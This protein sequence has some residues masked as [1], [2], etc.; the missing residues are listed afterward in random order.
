ML[1]RIVALVGL[2]ST[3]GNEVN[4]ST[5]D[6]KKPVGQ[7]VIEPRR[8]GFQ[9][10]MAE[11]WAY[12]RIAW[13]FA[14]RMIKRLYQGTVLGKFWLLRP[15][16][17]IMIGALI[18]GGLLGVPSEGVP[19]FLFFLVG[20]AIW[21]V[22][23]RSCIFV[24]RS[25]DMNKGLIKKLYFPRLV[26]PVS[27][28]SPAAVYF[29]VFAVLI[30]I[31]LLY[32]LWSEGRWYLVM[33]PRLLVSVFSMCM[34]VVLSL[35]LGLFTCIWQVRAKDVR[36]TL[37]YVL[38]FW[39]Y[40]TPVIYPLSQVPEEYRT[41]MMLNP[42]AG[43]VETFKWGLLGIGS[44]DVR[45]FG[46]SLGVTAVMLVAGMWYFHRNEAKSVDKM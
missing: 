1:R 42:M 13:F 23:E 19:Y 27:S 31:T 37:R 46:T 29:V 8:E 45:F 44:F 7:W 33:G 30:L 9:S 2:D 12:R 20:S 17:P 38:R 28:M 6:R 21:M 39:G 3:M 25:L 35:A 14:I 10:R 16:I 18:F 34:V 36:Y 24:C 26:V 40:L 15:V 32:F 5:I 43:Y 41:W 22:F 4:T 11:L